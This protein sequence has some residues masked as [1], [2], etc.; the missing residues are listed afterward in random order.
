MVQGT[1]TVFFAALATLA[2]SS[3]PAQAQFAY[4]GATGFVELS[5]YNT[6]AGGPLPFFNG[7]G[8]MV[9]AGGNYPAE[10]TL[11]TNVAL[12]AAPLPAFVPLFATSG[13][14][15]NFG[16]GNGNIIA[17]SGGGAG[18]ASTSYN[19]NDF[20]VNGVAS[21]VILGGDGLWR[22]N[23]PFN[24][25][26]LAGAFG[27]VR[28][29]LGGKGVNSYAEFGIDCLIQVGNVVGNNFIANQSY[30]DFI[31]FAYNGLAGP[32][33]FT[34]PGAGPNPVFQARTAFLGQQ[35]SFA[36]IAGNIINIPAGAYVRVAGALTLFGDPVSIDFDP[37]P[38]DM[39]L[40]SIGEDGGTN[41]AQAFSAPE[42]NTGALVA[43]A[44]C[45]GLMA[46]GI[47]RR[48]R[49]GNANPI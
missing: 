47:I 12:V 36:G 17:V 3:R 10:T 35:A 11:N 7:N 13:A 45:I 1:T 44:G 4:A 40:P 28:F 29:N 23:S 37:Y 31:S 18:L 19:V 46:F 16:G 41:A 9:Q 49:M 48:R 43:W 21:T 24:L 38:T 6:G 2:L 5:T 14:V 30:Q 20:N 33:A 32:T 34:V 27:A 22:N 42:A 15:G 39:P 26:R 8:A 25:T